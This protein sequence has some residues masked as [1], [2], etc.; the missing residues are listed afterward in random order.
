M[1]RVSAVVHN[2]S[3]VRWRRFVRTGRSLL[4]PRASAVTLLLILLVL[5]GSGV[6]HL[7]IARQAT[8][9]PADLA[10]LIDGLTPQDGGVYGFLVHD[11]ANGQLYA[12]NA[13]VP[14]VAASLYKLPLMAHIYKLADQGL[15]SLYEQLV[16]DEW[17]WSEGDDSYYDHAWLGASVSIN[18][19]LFAMGAWSSN[20]AAWALSTLVYWPDVQ[21][22]AWEI[23][24]TTGT[25]MFAVTPE[26]EAWPPPPGES[27][28]PEAMA[29]AGAFVDAVYGWAP[30]MIT[31]PHDIAAF[32]TGLLSR[33][34]V[35]ADASQA[36]LDILAQQAISDRL[37][38]LL[39]ESAWIAHKTGNLPQVVHDAGI[40]VT[41]SGPIVVV[42]MSEAMPDEW[43]AIDAIQHLGRT[44]FD[45]FS[46][47]GG[48]ASRSFFPD[49][50]NEVALRF[51]E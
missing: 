34:V 35:S 45:A 40:I 38:A 50:P 29:A 12:S 2:P 32:F 39:P 13:T 20:V 43:A 19:L 6:P 41:D 51:P 47:D 8:P 16:L 15:I 14:F 4:V 24:M 11:P 48:S 44:V 22:T 5:A 18:E 7:A 27:D 36:M 30:V 23:G 26:F 17:Y 3:F 1:R 10:A 46:G 9:E 37:P 21:E 25:W 33:T 49:A 31:N 42:G 28:A